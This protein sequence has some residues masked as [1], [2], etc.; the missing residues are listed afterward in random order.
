VEDFRVLLP[1]R[2]AEARRVSLYEGYFTLQVSPALLKELRP[3]KARRKKMPAVPAGKRSTTSGRGIGVSQQLAGKR[4]A[5]E[6]AS[7]G[8]S[9]DPANRRW[10]RASAREL[11]SHGRTTGSRQTGP[12]G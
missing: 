12:S 5:N 6:L 7:S 9:T 11:N 2:H 8:D 3:A 10:V 1:K 4:K